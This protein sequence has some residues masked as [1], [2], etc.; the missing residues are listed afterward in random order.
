MHLSGLPTTHPPNL[1]AETSS[2]WK[3]ISGAVS[4][5]GLA[6]RPSFR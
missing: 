4:E 2:S 3:P 5:S 6:D 1:S